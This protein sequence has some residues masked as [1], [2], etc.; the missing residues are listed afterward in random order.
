MSKYCK[1]L[2]YLAVSF[3][4]LLFFF[5]LVFCLD[6]NL[7]IPLCAVPSHLWSILELQLSN[8]PLSRELPHGTTFRSVLNNADNGSSQEPSTNSINNCIHDFHNYIVSS[9]AKTVTQRFPFVLK[10]PGNGV[11]TPRNSGDRRRS[12]RTC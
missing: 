3:S 9:G 11:E 1:Y 6:R 8:P 4:F 5:S 7:S 10:T 2:Y 12:S